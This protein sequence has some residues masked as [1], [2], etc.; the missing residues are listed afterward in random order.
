M[1]VKSKL[2]SIFPSLRWPNVRNEASIIY[3]ACKVNNFEIDKSIFEVYI[4]MGD[5]ERS[6]HQILKRKVFVMMMEEETERDAR[7]TFQ[8]RHGA[9]R[10]DY[11]QTSWALMLARGHCQ[12]INHKD[13]KYFRRRFRVPFQ[14]FRKIVDLC[15]HYG[16]FP[17]C[18][19]S[20]P[21]DLKVLAVLRKLTRL[22]GSPSSAPVNN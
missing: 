15:R 3:M 19:R 10:V 12:D 21:L 9:K 11:S 22:S 8:N 4:K 16:W 17:E 20:A 7:T 2:L 6:R 1:S 5:V 14:M 18:H 13:G